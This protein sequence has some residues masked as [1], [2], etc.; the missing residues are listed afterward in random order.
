M[1]RELRTLLVLVL[2]LSV[3]LS[4]CITAYTAISKPEPDS[5]ED[6]VARVVGGVVDFFFFG[7]GEMALLYETGVFSELKGWDQLDPA[8]SVFLL[9]AIG[10][11]LIDVVIRDSLSYRRAYFQDKESHEETTEPEEEPSE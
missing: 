5:R 11:I 7:I 2:C 4:G 9:F 10:T 6:I 1:F 8:I 3:L